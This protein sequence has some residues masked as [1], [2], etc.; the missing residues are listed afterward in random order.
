VSSALASLPTIGETIGEGRFE[1]LA[2]LGEGGM[3]LVFRARDHDLGR[4]VALKLLQPRYVGRPEREQRLINEAAYLRRLCGHPNVVEYVAEGRLDDREGWPWLTTEILDGTVLSWLLVQRKLAPSEVVHIARSVAEALRACHAAGVVHRDPTPG[5]VVLL[6]DAAHTVKLFDF[7][8]AGDL[9]GP[10]VAAGTHGRLTGIHDVP[11]T[12]GYMGPEQV[13][14][15]PADTKM[16]VFGFGVLLFEI[17]TRRNPYQHITEREA[18]IEAQRAGTLEAPRLHAWA[19][20]VPDD[21]A[22]LV[23]DCTARDAA[24]RPEMA[25]VLRRIDA[26]ELADAALPEPEPEPAETTQSIDAR[27]VIELRSKLP[28]VGHA[29]VVDEAVE[30]TAVELPFARPFELRGP[31]HVLEVAEPSPGATA[32]EQPDVAP[33]PRKRRLALLALALLVAA[34]LLWTQRPTTS[35]P[36]QPSELAEP[37]PKAPSEPVPAPAPAPAP[38]PAPIE[39]TSASPEPEPPSP[40]VEPPEPAPIKPRPKPGPDPACTGVEDD[41]RAAEKSRDWTTLANLT[42]KSKCFTSKREYTQLR[43]RATYQLGRWSDCWKAGRSS[44]DPAIEILVKTCKI[45]VGTP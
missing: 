27:A 20:G 15:A 14:T 12:L 1:L 44:N 39:A 18:F 28:L 40:S 25:E 19:Y 33:P 3:S 26:L 43:V 38:E 34:G 21:L 10:K 6:A 9:G 16:D 7:S 36:G 11:G 8:H 29:P 30:A 22:E 4:D 24:E 2:K 31:A 32:A 41:A 17:V 42:A 45:N 23:H 13:S 5:N 37:Q 35:E